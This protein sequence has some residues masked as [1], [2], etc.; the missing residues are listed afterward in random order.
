MI[1][2]NAL[3]CI[4]NTPIVRL[5]RVGKNSPIELYGKLEFMNPGGS[6]KDRIGYVLIEDA[7]KKGLLKPGGT[8]VE[9]TSGNTGVG[10]AVAAAIKGYKCVFVLPDKMSE[11]KINFLRSFGA[12]VIKTPSGVAADDPRSHYSVAKR[13]VKEIPNSALMDQFDNL[14]NQEIHYQK[15][16]PEILAQMPDI[17]V[18]ISGMGTGGTLSGAGRYLK[19]KRPSIKLVCIDPV[20]SIIHDV[21]YHGK[22][23]KPPAPYRMEGI[24]ED[25]IPKNFDLKILDDVIQ[26]EDQESFQYARDLLHQEGLYCGISSGG[27]VAGALKWA[28]KMGDAAKGLKVLTI[29][30]DSGDRYMSKL[31]NDEWLKKEGLFDERMNNLPPV[32]RVEGAK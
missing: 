25:F 24:G 3:Q 29:M 26:I 7:E 8:I 21:F 19:E 27:G 11:D 20:G 14:A 4:G 23:M 6:V 18:F 30:C 1:Y 5:N 16:G 10:L 17:D 22:P 2:A 13:M 15:T 9:A 12:Q 28:K 32:Q 31:W